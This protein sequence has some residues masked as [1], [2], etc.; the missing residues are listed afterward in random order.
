MKS[1]SRIELSDLG[2][3]GLGTLVTGSVLSEPLEVTVAYVHSNMLLR[4]EEMRAEIILGYQLVVVD[5]ERA[6]SGEDE[7]LSDLIC[8][9]LE[10]N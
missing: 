8:K 10:G 5:C 4:Y 7:V 3:R 2:C 1:D 9:C 6:N